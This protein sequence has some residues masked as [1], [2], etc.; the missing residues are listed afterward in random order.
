M[1]CRFL[2]C[3]FLILVI[4]SPAFAKD[5]QDELQEIEARAHRSPKASETVEAWR[6]KGRTLVKDFT[7]RWANSAKPDEHAYELA[8]AH[9][10][11]MNFSAHLKEYVAHY[12][13]ARS[14][15]EQA[16]KAH[17][18]HEGAK[19]LREQLAKYARSIKRYQERLKADE[20]RNAR[21]VNK[22]APALK[23]TEQLGESQPLRLKDL[24]GQVVLLNFWATW[25]G[26]CRQTLP[27]LVKLKSKWGAKGLEILGVTHYYGRAVVP[28][29][30]AL[31]R[32][33]SP[34][35][36]R[37]SIQ[38]C[39]QKLG[40]NYPILFAEKAL[41]SYEIRAIPTFV[42]IDRR[43]LVRHYR[44]GLGDP[45]SLESW[46]EKCLKEVRAKDDHPPTGD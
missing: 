23:A 7:E 17:P 27:N 42:L 2:F 35:A 29:E 1:D 16:L 11:G 3:L 10:L 26:P 18:K 21:F 12:N 41:E 45:K 32:K 15:T 31:K 40:V 39:A 9:R 38:A 30:V 20:K 33:L 25:C 36:E 28:G 13:A 34:S 24:R 19:A 22:P 5:I 6:S 8:R 37:L 46:I 44:V 14:Y 43:G 4:P